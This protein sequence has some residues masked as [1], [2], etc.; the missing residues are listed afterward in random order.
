[1]S[2]EYRKLSREEVRK[3]LKDLVSWKMTSGKLHREISFKS[4]EDAVAFLMRASLEIS[5]LDHH[6]E[7]FN[8]YN[9]IKI[10]LVTHDVD[11]ISQYD[12]ILANKLDEIARTMKA[13]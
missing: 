8:V 11:G 13:K 10:D 7:W 6:P 12:F 9:K 1:M 3:Q 4:F 5:K 2:E